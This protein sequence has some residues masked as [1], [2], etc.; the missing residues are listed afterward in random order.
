MCK[1]APT[2]LM[3]CENCDVLQY[4]DMQLQVLQHNLR[5]DA[6]WRGQPNVI[7]KVLETLKKRQFPMLY[8]P[9][10][11]PPVSENPPSAG[12][13]ALLKHCQDEQQRYFLKN[14]HHSDCYWSVGIIKAVIK[15]KG[16]T[17][18]TKASTS[19]FGKPMVTAKSPSVFGA[20]GTA[21]TT[22]FGGSTGS[23]NI[24]FGN[25]N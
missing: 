21:R 22:P 13:K 14:Q 25:V 8:A 10:K 23:S 16:D 1:K 18:T 3:E 6:F 19:L 12:L 9:Q 15:I 7:I 4:G 20:G 5:D 2:M 24:T 17:R 11:P